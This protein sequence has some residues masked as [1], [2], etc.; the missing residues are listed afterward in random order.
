MACDRCNDCPARCLYSRC[1][2]ADIEFPEARDLR[3]TARPKGRFDRAL[4][5]LYVLIT[6]TNFPARMGNHQE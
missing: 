1:P 5:R 6:R 3:P 2:L 4:N